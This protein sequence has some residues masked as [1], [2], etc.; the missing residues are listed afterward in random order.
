MSWSFEGIALL[1][2]TSTTAITAL[3]AVAVPLWTKRQ[4]VKTDRNREIHKEIKDAVFEL[5]DQADK[6]KEYIN[7]IH[8]NQHRLEEV[9]GSISCE[10][11]FEKATLFLEALLSLHGL[12]KTSLPDSLRKFTVHESD[13]FQAIG[14]GSTDFA[15]EMSQSERMKDT[16]KALVLEEIDAI[17]ANARKKY[18]I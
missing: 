8:V 5:L 17:W 7:L 6:K 14:S 18:P 9:A 1:I 4:D 10:E 2:T 13:L 11:E 15:S 12:P 16:T 3:S